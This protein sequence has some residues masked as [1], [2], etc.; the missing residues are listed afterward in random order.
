VEGADFW[1]KE[2]FHFPM[3]AGPEG[4]LLAAAQQLLF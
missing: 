3:V 4:Y 1:W 2:E